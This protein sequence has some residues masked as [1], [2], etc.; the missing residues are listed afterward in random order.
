VSRIFLSHVAKD[1]TTTEYIGQGLE[2]F[3]YSTWYFERDVIPGTSY[4]IQISQAIEEC[5]ALVLI[6]SQSA[7]KSDQVTKEV[8]AAFEKNKPIIPVLIGMTSTEFKERQ[9]EW[10]HALGGTAMIKVKQEKE[11][12]TAIDG[13]INGLK[14]RGIQPDGVSK[15]NVHHTPGKAPARTE[16]ER[17]NVTVLFADIS[18]FTAMSEKMDPEEVTD[19]MNECFS[20]MGECIEEHGGTIDKF[21]GDC[22]MVLFGAPKAQEDAPHRALNT[23]LEIRK[24]LKAFNEK[25]CL[26]S[27]LNI[28]IG[29]NTGPVI[30]GMMGSDKRQ[31]FT[32][33]G[34]TVNL[35][36]RME[37]ASQTGNILVAENTFKLTEGYFDFEDV[38]PIKVKGKDQPIQS[39]RLIGPRQVKTRIEASIGKGLTPFVGR[40]KE[41]SLLMDCYE[42]VK[43]GHGQVVGIMGEPGMGKS[44]II[45]EFTHSLPNDEYTCLEGGC[46]HYGDTIPYLPILDILKDC[47]DIKEDENEAAIKLKIGRK[48]S[49]LGSLPESILPSL[50]EILSLKVTDEA[51]S[52]LDGKQRRDKVFESIRMLLIAESQKK[53]LVVVVEDLHWIDKTSEEFLTYLIGSLATT[54]ILLILLFRPEY[55]P[56]WS[57]KTFYSQIRVDQLPKKTSQDLIQAILAGG[58]IAPELNDLIVSRTA[59]N[60]LFLEELTQN[61]LE[62][63]SI[64][65]AG[66]QYVLCCLPSDIKIPDTIQGIIA[67]RLDR[68]ESTLK[69]IMQMASVIGREFTF[70]ILQSV[71][72]MKEDLKSS[73]LTLQD[74]EFIYE[75]NLFPELEYIFKHALTRDVAYNSLLIKKRKETHE[76]VALAIETIYAERLEEFYEMLAYHY[77]LS[78]N[79]QKAYHYLKLSGE[80][81]ARSYAHQEAIRFY[82]E[83]LKVLD[84][85]PE[86]EETRREKL[87]V[88]LS[89]IIPMYFIGYPE[90]TL[91][92]LHEAERLALELEDEQGL[93][94]VYSRM[95]QYYTVKGNAPLAM[96]YTE[97][98]FDVA[99]KIESIELMAQ[100]ARDVCFTHFFAGNC[101][102]VVELCRRT[103]PSLEERHLKKDLY[104]SGV[105]VYSTLSGWC[106]MSLGYLGEFAEGKIVLGKGLQNALAINDR[107]MTGWEE[108]GHSI[109]SYFEG[110]GDS[111]VDHARKAIKWLEEA[112][113]EF[114]VGLAWAFLS[115]GYYLRGEYET[116]REHAGKGLSIQ[117]KIGLPFLTAWCYWLL[118]M[119]LCAAGDLKRA[120]ECAE[121]SL[122]LAQEHTVKNLEGIAWMLLGSIKGKMD[123]A[124]INEAQ[125]Q[126]QNGIIILEALRQ[127]ALSAIGYIFSGELF[128]DAGRRDEARENLKKAEA[129]YLEMKVTPKSYWLKRTQEALAKLVS[130]Q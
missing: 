29:I 74:L 60:P 54:R 87:G 58:E 102:K 72:A 49:Q 130:T 105:N 4:L 33:M 11:L 21:M 88:C 111:A 3:G 46:L 9:P 62:N 32:V 53:P 107:Y 64:E 65:K 128:A 63:G 16:G 109:L 52:K 69:K 120:R 25:K 98:C 106:G 47:F 22:V 12:P 8:V 104:T 82:Q 34:D 129:M 30:A 6:V 96:E 42:Q 118:A 115:G 67:D 24:R 108:N 23:A 89:I 10:R 94:T 48:I 76:K 77:S 41:M 114:F 37:S 81:A 68:L 35:A 113:A 121:K 13:I 78:E 31:D 97:K 55:N 127:K 39:Y 125:H 126:I 83:A 1:L 116:A 36:S 19:I 99:E 122:N 26:S 112:G 66:N 73:M 119:I 43:E 101:L 70:R 85:K 5:D 71:A 95:G 38:G 2:A 61:L 123:P 14:I 45:R 79:F 124:C 18:G 86:S 90:G 100:I 15:I 7:L 91:E 20:M 117:E 56:S 44:R 27:P 92:I 40:T 80:K 59:G 110:D 50:H 93:A 103:I 17:K 84:A 57:T 75:K 28:H 51:Y